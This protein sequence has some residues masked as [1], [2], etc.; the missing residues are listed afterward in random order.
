MNPLN[1]GLFPKGLVSNPNLVNCDDGDL[2][3]S[4]SISLYRASI[5]GVLIFPL[6]ST[7]IACSDFTS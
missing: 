5:L 2:A 1:Q 3:L 7:A 4:Q 6:R